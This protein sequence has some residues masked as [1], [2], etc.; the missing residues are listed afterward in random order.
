MQSPSCNLVSN[1]TIIEKYAKQDN[2]NYLA[3]KVGRV[4]H[5]FNNCCHILQDTVGTKSPSVGWRVILFPVGIFG[6]RVCP[7][8]TGIDWR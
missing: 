4:T 2:E 5:K 3:A 7:F 8:L 6:V 1:A